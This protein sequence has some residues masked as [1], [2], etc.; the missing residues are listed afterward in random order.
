MFSFVINLGRLFKMNTEKAENFD[1]SKRA[2]VIPAYQR[3]YKWND[4]R[5]DS[6]LS[7]IQKSSKFLGNIIIDE[8]NSE[9]EIIDGQ[10]RITTCYLALVALFNQY[11]GHP[12]E[13]NSMNEY[14]APN[15]KRIFINK[16]VGEYLD[17]GNDMYSLSFSPEHDIYRQ[18]KDFERAYSRIISFVNSLG[19]NDDINDFKSKLLDSKLLVLVNN[20]HDS[21]H[22]VEQI[23][24]DIN[25]KAQHLQAEDIFKG[26]CFK[27]FDK[28]MHDEL[29]ERWV[30]LKKNADLFKRYG[31]DDA[32]EYIY[33][34]LLVTED[35]KLPQDLT[36][37]GKHHLDNK[38]MDD[39]NI[40]LNNTIQYGESVNSYYASIKQTE[41]R[42]EDVCEESAKYRAT[43]DHLVLKEMSL[44]IMD[45]QSAVYQKLPFFHFINALMTNHELR[46]R[47]KHEQ[48]K[49]I[50]TNL[51]IY[52]GLFILCGGRKSKADIDQSI[53]AA[54]ST[55]DPIKDIS[56][57]AKELRNAQVKR[58]VVREV[59]SDEKLFFLAS[60]IDN[61]SPETNWLPSLYSKAM[62][63]S[64]EH[65]IVP[66]N[67]KHVITWQNGN[68]HF[69]IILDK[70]LAKANLKG[71]V[72]LLVMEQALNESLGHDDIVLKITK[73]KQ[74]Y[75]ASG[76][77]FP[78]HISYIINA[79]EK[80]PEYTALVSAKEN[81]E[82]QEIVKTKYL[83]FLHA[84]FDEKNAANVRTGIEELFISAFKQNA[85]TLHSTNA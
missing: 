29:K 19:D 11:E 82:S 79:I 58:F 20:E 46:S 15:N 1:Q 71:V 41:Y 31:F 74:W 21:S 64:P 50:I 23:F 76:R 7:D 22:P 60:V 30:Q 54:I 38:T 9:Y 85:E 83:D 47:I 67:K 56:K 25:E 43:S 14:I 52:T 24:L 66:Q 34:Y 44:G 40:L 18:A 63:Y 57:A 42:F 77:I 80:M 68:D 61:Y 16:S 12:L 32:S 55:S 49:K 51:F 75:G 2:L 6:L 78:K 36:K 3:E 48:L 70:E 73:I 26:H 27:R 17:L 69:D 65:F 45:L 72:N 4:Q 84:Y 59:Y 13:Q 37:S 8:T 62:S 5:I 33:T 28:A 53:Y 81:S 39:I 10:Q 35:A